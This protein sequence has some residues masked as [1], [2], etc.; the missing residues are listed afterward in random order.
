MQ[1]HI[2]V[3]FLQQANNELIKVVPHNHRSWTDYKYSSGRV[4]PSTRP[5]LYDYI[6]WG[7]PYITSLKLFSKI[8]EVDPAYISFLAQIKAKSKYHH[9]WVR[10]YSIAIALLQTYLLEVS[11]FQFNELVAEKIAGN[12]VNFLNLQSSR[13]TRVSVIRGLKL[14]N[15]RIELGNQIVLRRV[16]D[17]EASYLWRL[18]RG[19]G[20]ENDFPR[21]NTILEHQTSTDLGLFESD[22]P[23]KVIDN[24]EKIILALRLLKHGHISRERLYQY[25][26]VQGEMGQETSTQTSYGVAVERPANHSGYELKSNEVPNLP[27]MIDLVSSSVCTYYS[28]SIDRFTSARKRFKFELNDQLIDLFISL[29]ALFNSVQGASSYSIRMRAAR[30]VG[31]SP[32]ERQQIALLLQDG[33]DARSKIVHGNTYQKKKTRMKL[34]IEEL[35]EKISEITR[36]SIILVLEKSRNKGIPMLGKDFDDL[37]LN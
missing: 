13:L 36:E 4:T 31:K 29:E 11:S 30:L 5:D 34:D 9:D 18:I 25:Y 32:N 21:N 14:E 17:G 15:E 24:F 22:Y 10:P 28:V 16:E 2:V 37:I 35:V 12:F 3:A 20:Q 6:V 1:V 19:I 23:H 7:Q 8:I 27:Y 33:Y 26:P